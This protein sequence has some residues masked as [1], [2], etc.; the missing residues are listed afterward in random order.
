MTWPDAPLRYVPIPAQTRDAAPHLYYLFYRSPAPFDRLRDLRL[1]RDAD[2]A[3]H[4]GR[5][6]ERRLRAANDSVI[7]LNHVVHHGAIGHHVQNSPRLRTARRAI[8]QVAAVDSANRIGMFSG[9]TLAEGWACYASDLMEEIGFLTPRGS[10]RSSTRACAC[11]RARWPTSSCT[12][13]ADASTRPRRSTRSRGCRPRPR[14]PRPRKNSMFP[15][16]AVMYWLG[17]A[18]C[19]ALRRERRARGRAFTLQAFHDRVLSYGAIPVPLI[20][21]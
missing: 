1:R 4:A 15:G 7:T 10:P 6:A 12:A 18:R 16:T 14:E 13:A 5:R 17:T 19:T 9:G 8:G 20:S 3:E 11:W 2:R 21:S